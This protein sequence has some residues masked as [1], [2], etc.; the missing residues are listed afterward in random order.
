MWLCFSLF[1]SCC[2]RSMVFN[3]WLKRS[4]IKALRSIESSK[5]RLTCLGYLQ[6][7]FS[8]WVLDTPS[9]CYLV[10]DPRIE[11]GEGLFELTSPRLATF[12]SSPISN[13]SFTVFFSLTAYFYFCAM[14]EDP[15][16]VPKM[17]SRNSQRAVVTE[18]FEQWKFDEENF[19]VSCM[20]RKPLRSKHCKRCGRCVAKHDHHCPW[21]DNCV[22]ANNL[23]HFVSYIVC[24]EFGIIL[25]LRL[26]F[27]YINVLPAPVN[28][29]CNVINDALCDL[30]LRD[31]FTLVLDIWVV[32]QLVWI[33]MLCAVQLVQ[34][35]RNQTTY[36]NM[37]GHSIDRSYPSSRAFASAVTAGTTSLDAAGL[38]SAGQGPNPALAQNV[39][40]R[41]Q[42][43]GC[44][45]QWSS[46]LGIDTFFATARDGLRDSP[47][48]ARPKN[49]FSRGIVTNCQDFWCDPAPY[50]G[51]REP[52]S[53]MLG[54]EVVNYNRMYEVPLRM[55]SGGGYRSLAD[56]DLEQN[57]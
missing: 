24:L 1:R 21:I 14:T 29:Q 13:I 4:L 39:S 23:R 8:G 44:L 18:L 45:Q 46:L 12:S 31:T 43:N 16:F 9:T 17:N 41:H 49:P 27:N 37:R 52:G 38:S 51:R 3:G 55:H 28:P 56:N 22:G 19:C 30:V 6:A 2:L 57:A 53:A 26:T 33:T 40:H 35:S 50:F 20:V 7:L 10:S 42:K 34:I 48:T 47:R 11:R 15:G 25:F 54:G 32:I 36:E 5:R